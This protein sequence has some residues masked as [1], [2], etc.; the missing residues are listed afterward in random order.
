MTAGAFVPLADICGRI[1]VSQSSLPSR[2]IIDIAIVIVLGEITN[3]FIVLISPLLVHNSIHRHSGC[4]YHG[5]RFHHHCQD[6][7]DQLKMQKLS[8]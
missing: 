7:D 1:L 6:I 8:I 5:H 3:V 4:C 2:H